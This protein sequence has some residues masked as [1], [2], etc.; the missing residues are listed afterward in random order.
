MH[1]PLNS[2]HETRKHQEAYLTLQREEEAEDAEKDVLGCLFRSVPRGFEMELS[3]MT[4][5]PI[6]NTVTIQISMEGME[7]PRASLKRRQEPIRADH[8]VK[9]CHPQDPIKS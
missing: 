8:T 9:Q 5:E 2:Q 4:Q 3:E 6:R 1:G 7:F